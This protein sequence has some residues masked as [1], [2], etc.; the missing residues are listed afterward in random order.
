MQNIH[1]LGGRSFWI[2]NT[3][4]VGCLAYVFERVPVSPEQIDKVGCAIPFNEVAKYFNLKLKEAVAELR[5]DL[6]SAALTYVDVY[7]LKYELFSHAKK[8]GIH[9]LPFF[10]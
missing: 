10:L 4:P 7:S 3:G 2:H 1:H 9:R 5:K 6:P 8:H